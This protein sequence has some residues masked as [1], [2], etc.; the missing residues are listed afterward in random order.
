MQS[1]CARTAAAHLYTSGLRSSSVSGTCRLPPLAVSLP[2]RMGGADVL[3]DGVGACTAMTLAPV[4]DCC[5]VASFPASSATAVLPRAGAGACCT[6]AR[7]VHG[8]L[9]REAAP[10]PGPRMRT[11]STTTTSTPASKQLPTASITAS[12]GWRWAELLPLLGA[13]PPGA[14]GPADPAPP[15]GVLV[16]AG[17]WLG[18]CCG[19]CCGEESAGAAASA[20]CTALGGLWPELVAAELL[21]LLPGAAAPPAV[22]SSSTLGSAVGATA[23]GAGGLYA[24]MP[25]AVLLFWPLAGAKPAALPLLLGSTCLPAQQKLVTHCGPARTGRSPVISVTPSWLQLPSAA[26]APAPAAAGSSVQE[27]PLKVTAAIPS[28]WASRV[29]SVVGTRP[30]LKPALPP[31]AA[32]LGAFGRPT[33]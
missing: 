28:R 25:P 33:T 2:G 27:T 3:A 16:C 5:K 31:P 29:A 18:C 30:K 15:T 19:G 20:T 26:E 11:R 14:S 22:A 8:S 13:E 17:G 10:P 6:R 12:R 21:S 9:T 4:S 1:R 23:G 32:M 24:A 7:R